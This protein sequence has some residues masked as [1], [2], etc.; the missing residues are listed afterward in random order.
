M[1]TTPEGDAPGEHNPPGCAT[2]PWRAPVGGDPHQGPLTYS[3]QPLF[4]FF[5]KKNH[6]I[7]TSRVLAPEPEIFDLFA[8]SSVSE[9]VLEDCYLVCDSSIGPISF[10]SSGLYFEYFA[11]LGAAVDVLA[12]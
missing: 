8:W 6:H 2:P 9:T 10:S 1:Q 4:P 3:F 7:V 5:L 12:C 11:I